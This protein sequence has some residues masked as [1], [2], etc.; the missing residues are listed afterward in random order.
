M[1]IVHGNV[2]NVDDFEWDFYNEIE[3]HF[4]GVLIVF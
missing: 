1:V 4:H 3:W 2:D